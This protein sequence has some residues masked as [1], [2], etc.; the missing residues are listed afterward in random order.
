[1]IGQLRVL[2][3]RFQLGNP[4]VLRAVL[5]QS[6]AVIS[7]STALLLLH[8]GRFLPN[9]VDFYVMQSG[10]HILM[11]YLQDC[12]YEIDLYHDSYYP[13]SL[14]QIRA[15]QVFRSNSSSQHINVIICEG[16]HVLS[17]ISRFHSTLVMNYV[18]HYGVICLY[19]LWTMMNM[20][21]IVTRGSDQSLAIEPHLLKYIR[22]GFKL[23]RTLGLGQRATSTHSENAIRNLH[24]GDVLFIPFDSHADDIRKFDDAISWGLPH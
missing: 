22:R 17:T 16:P 1:M 10:Y 9:D 18:S 3:T 19:P 23:S 5:R 24:D 14:R 12:G 21:F 8:P 4:K 2:L 7:G 11:A 15:I 20:G 6:N 13:T